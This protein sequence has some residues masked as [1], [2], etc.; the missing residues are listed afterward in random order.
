MAPASGVHDAHAAA[1]AHLNS[2]GLMS[3]CLAIISAVASAGLIAALAPAVCRK[4]DV[5]ASG[6]ASRAATFPVFLW[7]LLFVAVGDATA[8]VGASLG[9]GG[10]AADHEAREPTLCFLQSWMTQFGDRVSHLFTAAL[11]FEL[12]V[13]VR[14]SS[15]MTQAA[16]MRRFKVA[17]C[18]VWSVAVVLT[19]VPG[20]ADLYGQA[21]PWCWIRIDPERVDESWTMRWVVGYAPTYAL[22]VACTVMHS[23]SARRLLEGDA[24]QRAASTRRQAARFMA[25]PAV[26]L[27]TWVFPLLARLVELQGGSVGAVP[28]WVGFA[29][30]AG[31]RLTGFANALVYGLTTPRARAACGGAVGRAVD[32]A[33]CSGS[34]SA[35]ACC[36]FGRRR[37]LGAGV[38][39]GAQ[40]R[41]SGD[42]VHSGADEPAQ[43][44]THV[45]VGTINP[46][47][48]AGVASGRSAAATSGVDGTGK[49]A[50]SDAGGGAG[51]RV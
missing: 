8:A 40:G 33:T 27:V 4:P 20:A 50:T 49:A 34:C 14:A 51:P 23:A 28:H 43:P 31:L 2:L 30:V 46:L 44:A 9:V 25:Y 7:Y 36:C 12:L 22:I 42:G 32:R 37:G 24:A 5:R 29:A 6:R 26:F 16:V 19:V 38:W 17:H 1:V 41:G 10:D 48:S 15:A 21:G 18:I 13:T 3:G 45:S 39:E 11:A 35:C 47:D